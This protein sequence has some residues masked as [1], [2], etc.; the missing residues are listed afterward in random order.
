VAGVLLT[1][2]VEAQQRRDLSLDFKRRS[3]AFHLTVRDLQ[4]AYRVT[5][6]GDIQLLPFPRAAVLADE[7]LTVEL[8]PEGRRQG[9]LRIRR[10]EEA[11]D[12]V[13]EAD[14]KL[15]GEVWVTGL[16][17]G[18]SF[19][20]PNGWAAP[21]AG[22]R[23]EFSRPVAAQALS[24]A[25]A[26][27]F[28]FRGSEPVPDCPDCVRIDLRGVRRF[29]AGEALARELANVRQPVDDPFFVEERPFAAGSVLFSP[30][31]GF[32]HRVEITSNPSMFTVLPVPGL[33]RELVIER[34]R[35]ESR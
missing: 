32:F 23:Q 8:S 27:L 26:Y 22:W 28:T 6:G 2:A 5:P 10:G 13:L 24:A 17:F 11:F 31:Q 21:G 33:A 14:G 4:D 29:V 15:A 34:R 3:L 35:E 7:D 20:P 9:R 25:A 1:P 19:L 12:L 16:P 18:Y 30:S